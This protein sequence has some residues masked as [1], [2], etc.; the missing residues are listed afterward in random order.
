MS[1]FNW[2]ATESF[3]FVDKENKMMLNQ[4]PSWNIDGENGKGDAIGRSKDAFYTYGDYRFIEGIEDC[5]VKV[6]NKG[7]RRLFKKYYYQGY[8]YPTYA[9]G[10]EVEPVGLSRDHTLN[11]VIAY[12][13]A[14]KSDKEI[15]EFVRHLRWK[16]SPFAK[17]TIDLHYWMRA[18]AGRRFAKWLSPRLTYY[19]NKVTAWW[20]KKV[21]D[22]IG[23]GPDF[24]ED[25]NTFHHIQNSF[26]PKCI[27]TLSKLLHPVYALHQQ[28][29]ETQ[30]YVD[31]KWKK[32]CQDVIC[33]FTPTY[34]YAI[35]LLCEHPENIT[36][37]IIMDYKSMNGGRWSG[38]MNIW[39]NDRSLEIQTNPDY[40]E[41]NV[42]DVDYLRKLWEE[43]GN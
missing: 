8:R 19:V 5:W 30:F 11:T 6:E 41:Y 21:Q 4:N 18:M 34:N 17:Q 16:I 22:K 40:L 9:R 38:I 39:W 1:N 24:E 28:A 32:K 7:I 42:M 20:Q 10:E 3:F 36:E 13:L 35:K 23:F 27:K 37:E 26:K 12:K 33:S 43:F 25:Q 14:G 31:G 2:D 29:W 15:W